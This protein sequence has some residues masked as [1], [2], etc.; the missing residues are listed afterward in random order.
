MRAIWE[1]WTCVGFL[2]ELGLTR[3]CFVFSCRLAS[4]PLLFFIHAFELLMHS[5]DDCIT[6]LEMADPDWPLSPNFE[7]AET[8]ANAIS[9][10][11]ITLLNPPISGKPNLEPFEL[12]L[13]EHRAERSKLVVP[14][15]SF[16]ISRTAWVHCMRG[17]KFRME[18]DALL[19]EEN[20]KRAELEKHMGR[21]KLT[22]DSVLGAL[23]V[24]REDGAAWTNIYEAYKVTHRA[25]S[26]LMSGEKAE[27]GN[28]FTS[29]ELTTL[30]WW[31]NTSF[32]LS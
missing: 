8:S 12:S 1:R 9:R 5:A 21:L 11:V 13:E 20:A 24:M 15:W 30:G 10:L 6:Q 16:A 25:A 17:R 7:R 31:V 18:L 4:T 29:E 14:V 26:K 28:L 19:P 2:G 22:M 23:D 3:A 27:R 32:Q